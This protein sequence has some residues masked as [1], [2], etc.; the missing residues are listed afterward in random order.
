MLTKLEFA[1]GL[2]ESEY[3]SQK[4]ELEQIHE[5]MMMDIDS[6]FDPIIAKF[7]GVCC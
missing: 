7:L 3:A 5:D 1:T 2:Y 4:A 6:D